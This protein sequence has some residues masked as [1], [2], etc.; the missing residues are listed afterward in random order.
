VFSLS[1]TGG[2]SF[3]AIDSPLRQPLSGSILSANNPTVEYNS[4]A[5]TALITFT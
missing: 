2:T 4:T 3:Y 1:T 5:A